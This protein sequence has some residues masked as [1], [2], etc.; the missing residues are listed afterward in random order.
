MSRATWMIYGA[1]GSTGTLIAEEAIRRGHQPLL[2]GRLAEKLASL[3]KR[4]GLPWISVG[5]DEPARLQRAVSEAGAVLNA[6]GP[7]IVTSPPLIQ[8]CLAAGTHYLDIANEIPILQQLFARDEAA[9]ERHIALIGGVGFGVVASNSLVAHVADQLPGATTLELAVKAENGQ[10]SPGAAKSTLEALAGGGRVY[11]NG[12]IVPFR[13]GKGMK[14]LGFPDGPLDILPVPSGD[15]EAAHQATGIPNITSF[16]PFRRSA[17]FF[18][19]LVQ[20]GLS[21]RPLRGRLEA[22]IEKRGT[23]QRESGPGGQR[24]SYAWARAMDQKGQ[25]VEAWL[26]MGEGYHFTAASSVRAVERV[27]RDRL[28]G[29]LTPA[30]A[31]GADFVLDIDGVRRWS[32][33]PRAHALQENGR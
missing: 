2:A 5:L 12:R 27:L 17:A 30:R 24:A 11:R 20:S 21:L 16:I 1:A 32:A 3:G 29:A 18:L 14:T 8:A 13:L 31:F 25:Q 10:R 33:I 28:S 19:P 7:F 26:E 23:R 6:A 4:L 22:A 15:L 9:R